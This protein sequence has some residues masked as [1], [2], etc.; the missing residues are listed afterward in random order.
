[1]RTD[2]P[3]LL[4][5]SAAF[6]MRKAA[7]YTVKVSNR[8]RQVRALFERVL[9]PTDFSGLSEKTLEFVTGLRRCGTTDV[10]LV[11]VIDERD[12][13][14]IA[15][16]GSAY[17]GSVPEYETEAQKRLREDMRENLRAAQRKAELAGLRV[18]IRM[19]LGSPGQQIV[20]IANAERVS[21]IVIGSHGKSN[22][23]EMLLGSVSEYVIKNALQPVLVVKRNSAG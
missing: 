7:L 17:L 19:P 15:S 16:G 2:A 8:K 13:T 20:N 5:G 10:I 1:M 21:L 22:I 14:T 4:P 11:H 12:I 23:R 6:R 18:T 3:G 9:F